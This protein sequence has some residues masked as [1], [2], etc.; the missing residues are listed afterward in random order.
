MQVRHFF[1][2]L[3]A[4]LLA[5]AVGIISVFMGKTVQPAL[6]E[7]AVSTQVQRLSS[8]S[9]D[10][11]SGLNSAAIIV[12]AMAETVQDTPLDHDALTTYV[13][14]IINQAK[15]QAI[16]GGGLWPEAGMLRPDRD[17]D[18]LFWGREGDGGLGYLDDYN[19]PGTVLYREEPWYVAA[20]PLQA[21]QISWSAPL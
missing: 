13:P 1:V 2:V 21:G 16:A 9:S 10:I 5:A 11:A 3:S 4:I 20:K 14:G 6:E 8:V 15:N 18:S 19:D 7:Q 17:R 12:T